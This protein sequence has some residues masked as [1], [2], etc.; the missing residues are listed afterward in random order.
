MRALFQRRL[1]VACLILAAGLGA[2]VA[3]VPEPA[4]PTLPAA[5]ALIA[6]TSWRP[7][8]AAAPET[9]ALRSQQWLLDDGAGDQ[10]LL[11][12]GV[13]A[14][15]RAVLDWTGELGYQGSGFVV[16]AT[17]DGWLR[18]ANGR[19]VA[20]DDA[21]VEHLAEHRLL[22]SAVIGPDGVAPRGWDLVLP[23]AWDLLRERSG[24]YYVVR[25]AVADGP[26]A[27]ARADA[28][29]AAALG[30]LLALADSR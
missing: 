21:T 19:Q 28:L 6:G 18:L 2:A 11:Y 8:G 15:P 1:L 22:R 13:T 24:V 26:R 4:T 30:R 20:V 7:A 23:V 25:V 3:A 10:A 16:V 12:V 9:L 17:Q 29:L 14:Q 27:G 5:A